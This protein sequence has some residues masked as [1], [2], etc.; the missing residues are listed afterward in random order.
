LRGAVRRRIGKKRKNRKERKERREREEEEKD[1]M[2]MG[3]GF[4]TVTDNFI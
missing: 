2:K 3:R 4:A 1:G